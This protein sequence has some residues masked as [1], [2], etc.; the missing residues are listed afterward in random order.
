MGS[1]YEGL[2]WN[3]QIKGFQRYNEWLNKDNTVTMCRDLNGKYSV[4]NRDHFKEF[5]DFSEASH[6]MWSLVTRPKGDPK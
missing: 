4:K 2:F 1:I 6:F 3:S 5:L